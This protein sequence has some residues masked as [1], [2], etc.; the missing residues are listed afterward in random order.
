MIVTRLITTMSFAKTL[1]LG[2]MGCFFRLCTLRG[3]FG[4]GP[5]PKD[6]QMK[7]GCS[8]QW[9]RQATKAVTGAARAQWTR[10][11]ITT[12]P[13]LRMILP[14]LCRHL[15]MTVWS[16]STR[17]C[18]PEPKAVLQHAEQMAGRGY[19]NITLQ[20]L[21]RWTLS[22][23]NKFRNALNIPWIHVNRFQK[24]A[25]IS[26]RR[27]RSWHLNRWGAKCKWKFMQ[28]SLNTN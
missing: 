8:S 17:F 6:R 3:M 23:R 9:R 25:E 20:L 11:G 18:E 14:A 5:K 21:H 22:V 28:E 2:F 13:A 19:W 7:R 27:V 1:I 16:E 15:E 4:L 24:D 10:T 12:C 26:S